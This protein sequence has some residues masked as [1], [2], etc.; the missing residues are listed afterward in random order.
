MP[1]MQSVDRI[2]AT[3]THPVYVYAREPFPSQSD[4]E[5]LPRPVEEWLKARYPKVEVGR[6][7]YPQEREPQPSVH[8][9]QGQRISTSVYIL[10]FNAEQ[11]D[12]FIADWS[13]PPS[14][15]PKSPDFYFIRCAPRQLG[16]LIQ[17]HLLHARQRLQGRLCN[18]MRATTHRP[19][20]HSKDNQ[21][22]Y[23]TRHH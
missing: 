18:L 23:C 10:G 12:A 7:C 13:T 19:T 20:A 8:G 5:R 3:S 21:H 16:A 1:P 4:L 9:S 15:L 17:W 6:L 14:L 22:D 11:A 2:I